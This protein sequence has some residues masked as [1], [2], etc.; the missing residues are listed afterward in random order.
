MRTGVIKEKKHKWGMGKALVIL[1]A[2]ACLHMF[3]IR[4]VHAQ[5]TRDSGVRQMES[6]TVTAQK[7]EENVQDVP[8]SI[9]LFNEQRI[10]DMRIESVKDVADFTPNLMLFDN[11]QPGQNSPTMRGINATVDSFTVSTGLYVDGVPILMGSGFDAEMY[12]IERI[13]VLRGPQGTLYGKNTEAG[14]INIITRLPD[15]DFAGRVSCQIGED[16]KKQAV[17]SLSGPVLEDKFYFGISGRYYEKDGLITHA[18]TGRTTDDRKRWSGRAHLRWTPTDDLDISFIASRF[19]YDDDAINM[20]YT[21]LG[22]N[23]F[24]FSSPGYRQVMS[25][26]DGK[27]ESSDTS[28]TLKIT[29]DLSDCLSVTSITAHR[30]WEDILNQDFDFTPYT[31]GHTDKDG[32]YAILS[33]ELRLNLS[34]GRFNFLAGVYYD[35]DQ[36][37]E[38]ID[39]ISDYPDMQYTYDRQIDSDTYAVFTHLSYALTDKLKLL[40]GLR[41]EQSDYEFED[42]NTGLKVDESW[43]AITPKIAAQYHFTP[44]M[45]VY[46]NASQ[47]YRS[48]GF[49]AY[50]TDPQYYSYDAESLWS[51]ELGFKSAFMDKRIIVNGAV[52]YMDISDMQVSEAV[53]YVEGYTTNAAE[54]TGTGAEIEITAR[55]YEG[56]TLMAG[57][58]YTHIEFDSFED[59]LGNYEGNKAPYAPDYTF[60]IGA[61]YRHKTGM[62]ARADLVGYGRMYFDKDNTYSRDPYEVVNTRIGYETDKFDIYLYAENLFDREYDSVGHYGGYYIVYSEPRE[63]G[64]QIVYRF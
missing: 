54:A 1:G 11:G 27:N 52:F 42:N 45:M 31:I 10:E 3:S 34:R 49:N 28:E 4:F 22:Y 64:M 44:S 63:V 25:N 37:E 57:F 35:R 60:N 62:Y 24:G 55:V 23:S 7:Q 5:E 9:S 19:Q 59:A 20:N 32:E 21:E 18:Q 46:A 33:Q 29:Y 17:V 2:T 6:I 40:G 61:Q 39:I 12:D 8:M 58:G 13:E 43:D 26:I 41:Y 51:Y 16:N 47:G 36:I 15:N 53:N 48:G 50:A 56:L 30:V 38:F 14:A